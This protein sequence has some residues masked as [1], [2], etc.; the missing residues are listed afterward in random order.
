[1]SAPGLSKFIIVYFGTNYIGTIF[2]PGYPN[3]SGWVPIH[4]NTDQWYTKPTKVGGN[5]EE[6]TQNIL[7]LILC[8]AC[9]IWKS[10]GQTIR[11]KVSLNLG[12]GGK[13]H[14]LYYFSMSRVTI[15]LGLAY[16]KAS[17]TTVSLSQ[18]RSTK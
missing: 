9:K 2:F 6:H 13:E 4:P 3:R 16:I 11:G 15:F 8:W 10:Q 1:M 17:R 5:F 7:S 12:S 14:G 18:Y